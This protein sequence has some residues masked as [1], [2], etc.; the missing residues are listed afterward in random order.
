M[1]VTTKSGD[2]MTADKAAS[3]GN[4]YFIA[5]LHPIF[6]VMAERVMLSEPLN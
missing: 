6:L 2:Q 1:P 4:E 5:F 3:T